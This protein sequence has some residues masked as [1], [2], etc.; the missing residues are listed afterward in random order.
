MLAGKEKER[1]MI[2]TDTSEESSD[3]W[4]SHDEEDAHIR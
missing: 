3:F 2:E 1:C 4:S